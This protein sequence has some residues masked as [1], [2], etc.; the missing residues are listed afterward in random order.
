M[1]PLE[2]FFKD[3][4]HPEGIPTPFPTVGVAPGCNPLVFTRRSSPLR[5]SS[6]PPT[7][8]GFVE[9]GGKLT[10]GSRAL[11]NLPDRSRGTRVHT[12][13]GLTRKGHM[14]FN[15]NT[16]GSVPAA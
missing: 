5:Y 13:N 10:R 2:P 14:S 1:T 11:Q 16:T 12:R 6:S 9:H 8:V 15:Q 7:S 4:P 3:N